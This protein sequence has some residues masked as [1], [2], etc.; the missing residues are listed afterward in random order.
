MEEGVEAPALL[1]LG[2]PVQHDL[3]AVLEGS[4]LRRA[5]GLVLLAG[6]EEARALR[7]DVVAHRCVLE[8]AQVL[9]AE[10]GLEGPPEPAADVPARGC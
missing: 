6:P 2:V 8:V 3:L 9:H 4:G 7:V 10:L 5:L 1:P